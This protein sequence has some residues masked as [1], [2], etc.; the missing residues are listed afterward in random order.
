MDMMKVGNLPFLITEEHCLM[1]DTGSPISMSN[2]GYIKIE[3]QYCFLHHRMGSDDTERVMGLTG[4]DKDGLLGMD[5]L[6]D[7]SLM[8]DY[9]TYEAFIDPT[10]FGKPAFTADLDMEVGIPR[11]TGT[12]FGKEHKFFLDTGSV[13]SF[14]LAEMT[15]KRPENRW[16]KVVHPIYGPFLT[17]VYRLGVRIV[18]TEFSLLFGRLPDYLE[19]P[20]VF[21]GVS[22]VIGYEYLSLTRVLLDFKNGKLTFYQGD[23]VYDDE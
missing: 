22:G 23:C 6:K 14:L 5:I 17:P 15:K 13:L 16:E 12:I 20:L 18:D 11:I 9:E 8:M 4:T 3:D 19:Q 21:G 1:I 2:K 10:E 7:H